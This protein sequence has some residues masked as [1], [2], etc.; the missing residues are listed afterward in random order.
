MH[1]EV[2]LSA[3]D[4]TKYQVLSGSVGRQTVDHWIDVI[5]EP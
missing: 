1:E 5:M 3:V 2:P 4:F